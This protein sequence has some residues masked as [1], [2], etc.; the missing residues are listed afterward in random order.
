MEK[1][2]QNTFEPTTPLTKANLQVRIISNSDKE[3]ASP[4]IFLSPSDQSAFT[5]SNSQHKSFFVSVDPIP[6]EILNPFLIEF[7]KLPNLEETSLFGNSE[8]FPRSS[9]LK[10]TDSVLTADSES[11]EL[12]AISLKNKAKGYK[13]PKEEEHRVMSDITSLHVTPRKMSDLREYRRHQN[14]AISHLNEAN[15]VEIQ[16]RSLMPLPRPKLS[17]NKENKFKN[18]IKPLLKYK[19]N[20]KRKSRLGI[21][22]PNNRK[23]MRI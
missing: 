7:K 4:D 15:N 23:S 20:P 5:R 16:R 22:K 13:I 12:S 9:N 2:P 10:K 3:N 17:L 18:V 6:D 21:R 14:S 19:N 8:T 1:L 11:S